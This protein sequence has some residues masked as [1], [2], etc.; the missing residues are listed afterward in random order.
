M[1]EAAFAWLI[2][3]LGFA[4]IASIGL[5]PLRAWQ[6]SNAAIASRV[7]RPI[8]VP[9]VLFVSGAALVSDFHITSRIFRCLTTTYCG[10][11]IGSGWAYLA[12]LGT[13]YICFEAVA[14]FARTPAIFWRSSAE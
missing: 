12:M 3:L 2:Y 13:V 11:G 9:I 6:V 14:Y 4:G 10:P 8:V 5:L 7:K 1:S